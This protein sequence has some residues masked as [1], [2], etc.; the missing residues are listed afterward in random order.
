M[1]EIDKSCD[2]KSCDLSVTIAFLFDVSFA[3]RI[4][5]KYSYLQLFIAG[6]KKN[7]LTQ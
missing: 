4:N 3:K 7:L 6:P 1:D 2:Y 5:Y